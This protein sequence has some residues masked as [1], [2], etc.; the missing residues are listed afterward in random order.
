MGHK[1]TRKMVYMALLSAIAIVLH[2]T[3]TALQLPLPP[4]M[5]LG[6]ANIISMVVIELYGVKEMFIVN[7]FRVVVSSLM[8]G[9]FLSHPFFISC[10]GVFIK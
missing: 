5:K 8:T 6:L 2:M 7:F 4:G 3:E 10:G 9:I 1:K